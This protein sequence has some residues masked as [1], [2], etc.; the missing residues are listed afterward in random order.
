[1]SRSSQFVSL[2]TGLLCAALAT[3]AAESRVVAL[4][5]FLVEERADGLPWRYADVAGV[6]V[7]STCSERLTREL[8]ATHHRLHTL[9]GELLPPA[10]QLKMTEKQALLF[11]D[12]AH[13]PATSQ[14]VLAQLALTSAE[15]DRLVDPALPL[16]DGRLRRRPPPPRYTFLPNLRLWDRDSGT[17]FAVV[18][19]KEFDARRVALTSD[20][21]AYLVRNRLPALPPWFVSGVLTLHGRAEFTADAVLLERLEWPLAS[22]AAALRTGAE[23]RRA[24]L[25]LAEFF[26]GDLPADGAAADG[27]LSL[28]QAQAA[29]FV[30]WG[31]GGRG[32][33]RR[34]ALW[35]FVERAATEPVTAAL[36]QECF[37]FDFATAQSQLAGY[38]PEATGEKLTLRAAQRPRLP[39]Y[40]L[41]PASEGEIARLK[42]DWE[43]LEID[44]VKT[45][46]PALASKYA[47]QAR[48]TLL[49]AHE[50]GHR[51]PRLLAVLGL[52]EVD[53][54]NDAA[55]REFL[56]AAAALGQPL[57]PRA[58]FE[59]ARLRLA[60][61]RGTRA[62]AEL[63]LTPAQADAVLGPLAAAREQQPP[64]A[65]A[66][67]LVAEVLAAGAQAPTRA[68][69]AVLEEG[70]RIF[71][72]RTELVHRAAELNLRHGYTDTARWL[73]TLGLTLAPDAV[74]RARFDA[75]QARISP[76][77]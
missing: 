11:I 64:L 53:T 25:P 74:A 72:R 49:R 54:G 59:L 22:G 60:A 10:L 9:L 16:D 56:E 36:F 52:C 45:Q 30:H 1:M 17:L 71:P 27:A 3:G 23:A 75:L 57:R 67:E 46:F 63:R 39:D 61:L 55:A 43:R 37:G 13:Q 69:L 58:W 42:G 68:Q 21:V 24:L 8:V 65:E 66:Y 77:K 51:D 73:I 38:L 28:W 2:A 26:A 15:Q 44:Y 29:L 6:E 48:R 18:N 14:E 50:R 5:P 62:A 70:V 19:E 31:L 12:S 32:A 35:K 7:L 4:P 33:P 47:E 76:A 41:R 40:V 34:A 20:Y